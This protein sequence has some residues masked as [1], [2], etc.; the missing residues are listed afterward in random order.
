[1]SNLKEQYFKI[2][3]LNVFME[4]RGAGNQK[5][6]L[7]AIIISVFLICAVIVGFLF[8]QKN[9]SAQPDPVSEQCAFACESEQK[10]AF[11]NVERTVG[12]LKL[13]CDELAT[14]SQYTSY[15]VETCATISCEEYEQEQASIDQT[16]VTGLGGTWQT[17][18]ATGTCPQTGD[19]IVRQVTPSDNPPQVGQICCR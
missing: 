7:I 15:N 8:F 11:C 4:K 12:N 6:I 17:S 9:K 2:Y 5:K 14:N 19:K 3:L 16:C 10:V 18:E 1:M 13:T